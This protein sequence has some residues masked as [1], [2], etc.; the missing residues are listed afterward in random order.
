[1]HK[2]PPSGRKRARMGRLLLVFGALAFVSALLTPG[3][4]AELP[5]GANRPNESYPGLEVEYGTLQTPTGAQLRTIVTHPEA[6]GKR[7]PAIQF[8]QW[9]SCDT[10]ELPPEPRD[11]WSKM[12]RRLITE[13]HALV[14]RT[15]KSGVGDSRGPDCGALDYETELAHHRFAFEQLRARADVD[16][17]RI[18]VFGASMGSTMAPLIARHQPVRG[19]ATWGGGA[20]T[21]YE[22]QLAFDRR[23]MEL[24]GRPAHE[25]APAM[26]AHAEFQ[27]LYLVQ[28]ITPAEVVRRRPDLAAVPG[29]VIGLDAS[30]QYGRP[31]AFHWQA[32]K[33]NWAAAWVDVD[34]PVLALL[35]EYDWFEEP[36][37][38]EL[39]ARIANRRAP[40]Q[41]RFELIPRMDHNFVL[42]PNAEAAFR[43]QGGT[44][45]PDAAID[46]LLPWLRERLQ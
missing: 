43:D 31:F 2:W 24:S 21:W 36:R 6:A 45:N 8:V 13:S 14:L 20:R 35:G 29:S 40:G 10:V 1:V 46:V 18:V 4:A 37:S 15:E 34:A 17:Q 9:L 41:G 3:G 22:R 16:P 30:G 38:A 5:R 12:L 25:I 26:L 39:I 27:F 7:L 11:G 19:V 42:F 44:P 32:A 33:Q 28:G 23:A